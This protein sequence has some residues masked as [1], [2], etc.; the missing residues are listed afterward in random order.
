MADSWIGLA[1]NYNTTLRHGMKRQPFNLTFAALVGFISLFGGVTI[2]HSPAARAATPLITVCSPPPCTPGTICNPV[3]CNLNWAGYIVM[4][5]GLQAINGNWNTQCTGS[6]AP[7][8]KEFGS[9]IGIGGVNGNLVQTGTVYFGANTYHPF[10]EF[11]GYDQAPTYDYTD[12]LPCGTHIQGQIWYQ[13]GY[14]VKVS[15]QTPSGGSGSFG[16]CY[17]SQA[18]A[19]QTTAEWIDERPICVNARGLKAGAQIGNFGWTDWSNGY[20]Y[21]KARNWHT[22]AGWSRQYALMNA[23]TL[24]YI[25]LVVPNNGLTS[26]TAFKD[27][28]RNQDPYPNNSCSF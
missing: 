1:T 10:Y 20:A 18:V 7:N 3:N 27:T 26:A 4:G 25:T 6:P 22:I 23:N 5:S 2:S 24:A 15:W 13:S 28:Y 8:P 17:P 11:P 19:D 14:C 12:S 21:S 9:W 16:H